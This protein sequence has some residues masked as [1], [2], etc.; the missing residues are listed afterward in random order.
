MWE[1]DKK[2]VLP[3]PACGASRPTA[4]HFLLMLSETAENF[5]LSLPVFSRPF[6]PGLWSIFALIDYSQCAWDMLNPLWSSL[7][8]QAISF[9]FCLLLSFWLVR[10][11]IKIKKISTGGRCSGSS[12][13]LSAVAVAVFLQLYCYFCVLQSPCLGYKLQ[14]KEQTLPPVS[15]YKLFKLFLARP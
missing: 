13:V 9:F 10:K 14:Q 8:S 2:L 6:L 5:S 3:G 4:F 1:E 15:I 12:T 7:L 11:K